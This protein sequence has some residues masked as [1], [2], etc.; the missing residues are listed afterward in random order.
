MTLLYITNETVVYSFNANF[1]QKDNW[2][3]KA[4]FLDCGD[5]KYFGYLGTHN[6]SIII[7]DLEPHSHYRIDAEVL[8]IDRYAEPNFY[9]ENIL[10][11]QDITVKEDN[12][13]GNSSPEQF[14]SVSIVRT[15]K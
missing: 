14:Y 8:S 10:A 13:F 7:L 4:R 2:Q 9:V 3:S 6:S 11:N 15:H 5:I 1:Q 12:I